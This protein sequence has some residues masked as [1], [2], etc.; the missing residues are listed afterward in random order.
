MNQPPPMD[1]AT[2][3][4]LGAGAHTAPA[5]LQRLTTD[6]SVTVRAALAL[7]PAAP[8]QADR[9]LARDPDERV[10]VLLA[11]KLALLLPELAAPEQ[12]RLQRQT[13]ETLLTLVADEVERVRSVVAD[14]LKQ[15]PNAPHALVLRLAQDPAVTVSEPV[16]RFSPLLTADDLL[17]LIASAP[18]PGTVAAVAGR[19]EISEAVS[20]AIAASADSAAIRA[21]LSN[22]SAHIREATLDGLI[23]Q[24]ID[25][26]DW[27]EP[28]V[29]RPAL[30]PGGARALAE[31]VTTHLLGVLAARDDL[32]PELGEELRVRLAARLPAAPPHRA[33]PTQSE[34]LAEARALSSAGL[35]TEE[36][37]LEAARRG[38]TRL[39]T[40]LLAVSAGVP[41]SVVDRAAALRSAKGLVSLTWRAGFSMRAG[42]ALQTLLGRLAPG[43]I[44]SAG[45][46]GGF[47][48]AIEEMR[49]QLDF[50]GRVGR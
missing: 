5:E 8:P 31:I 20:D 15:M 21:L 32:A 37:V 11:R 39:A 30:S 4:R 14:T 28:L 9:T 47:P 16:I 10:R 44:L 23:A 33:A 13:Y 17:M 27:H 3:V 40:A 35:L 38:E 42:N 50:L 43:A 18:S 46:G 36:T 26:T 48:L 49:W 25:H 7:N 12:T 24:A 1:E 22:T 29:R 34:A 19:P 45:P 6:A 2:R 41:V